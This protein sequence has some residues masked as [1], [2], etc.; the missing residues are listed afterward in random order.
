M[1]QTRFDLIECRSQLV[2]SSI[3]LQD[4]N[5][6]PRDRE[7]KRPTDRYPIEKS[8]DPNKTEAL[9]RDEIQSS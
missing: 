4:N 7:E 2:K 5:T 3:M 9:L 6:I 1:L 8:K